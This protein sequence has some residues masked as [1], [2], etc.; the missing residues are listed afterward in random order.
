MLIV[1][2]IAPPR[3][4]GELTG[5]TL[6]QLICCTTVL[7]GYAKILLLLLLLIGTIGQ[8]FETTLE[9]VTFSQNVFFKI[10]IN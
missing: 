5:T 3:W 4:P 9:T 6:A 10:E 1:A 2:A 7:A 8:F